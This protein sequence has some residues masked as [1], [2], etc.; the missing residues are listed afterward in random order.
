MLAELDRECKD[1]WDNHGSHARRQFRNIVAHGRVSMFE[2]METPV[3]D[4]DENK[5][6]SLN[7]YAAADGIYDILNDISRKCF[8]V[9]T[10]LPGK[11]KY[12]HAFWNEIDEEQAWCFDYSK[13]P[14]KELR[15]ID[16]SNLVLTEEDFRDS[17]LNKM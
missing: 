4:R 11:D 13:Y 14:T 3:E 1:L 17:R 15:P 12:W 10:D 8:G 2:Q 5:A 16:T 9:S 7:F 6:A